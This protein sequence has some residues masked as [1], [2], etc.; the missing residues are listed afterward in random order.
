MS[1]FTVSNPN[2]PSVGPNTGHDCFIGGIDTTLSG[3]GGAEGGR[4]F[5]IWACTYFDADLVMEWVKSRCDIKKPRFIAGSLTTK[6]ND[7]VSV[8]VVGP[9]HPAL[10]NGVDDGL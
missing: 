5:A 6:A 9:G 3:W 4:S 2:T 1:S 8:Y 7:H 10:M